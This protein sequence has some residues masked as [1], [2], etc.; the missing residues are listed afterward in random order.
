MRFS[1]TRMTR[2]YVDAPGQIFSLWN[3]DRWRTAAR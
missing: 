3:Y 1:E 2:A